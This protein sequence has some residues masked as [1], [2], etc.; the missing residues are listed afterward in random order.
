MDEA[1]RKTITD[2]LGADQA[3]IHARVNDAIDAATE[4]YHAVVEDARLA[5]RQA[6]EDAD[7]AHQETFQAAHAEYEK[8]CQD[9]WT[10]AHAA[11]YVP[12]PA[13]H[14]RDHPDLKV[15]K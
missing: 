11:G 13:E 14:E 5:R 4:K 10:A 9:A 6:I 15:E 12:L 1:H 7:A 3:D 8:A 2:T